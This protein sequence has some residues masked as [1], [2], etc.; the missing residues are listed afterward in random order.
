MS[1]DR[2]LVA[3]TQLILDGG[4][5]PVV[6]KIMSIEAIRGTAASFLSKHSSNL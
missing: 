3:L 1:D 5:T 2:A 6:G 4:V